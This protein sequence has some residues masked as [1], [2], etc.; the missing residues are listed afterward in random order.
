MGRLF[1]IQVQINCYA[2]YEPCKD[3]WA[4]ENNTNHEGLIEDPYIKVSEYPYKTKISKT[5]FC[6]GSRC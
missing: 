3:K 2:N 1:Q 6:A 5:I 4:P